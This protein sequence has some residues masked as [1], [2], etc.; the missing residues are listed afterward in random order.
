MATR[1]ERLLR[2][3]ARFLDHWLS[4]DAMLFMVASRNRDFLGSGGSVEGG[5]MLRKA[6]SRHF[7]RL[8][9]GNPDLRIVH[10]RPV[11]DNADGGDRIAP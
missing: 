9:G 3:I 10:D 1:P 11:V 6:S 4:T 8:A 5:A 7:L 2:P